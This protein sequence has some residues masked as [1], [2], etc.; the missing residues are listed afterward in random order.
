M[1][2]ASLIPLALLVAVSAAAQPSASPLA[3]TWEGSFT[4]PQ[5]KGQMELVLSRD[6]TWHGRVQVR[7]DHPVP[8]SDARE[9]VVDG[10]KVAFT[11]DLMGSACKTTAS[12][13]AGR[14][15][16]RMDCGAFALEFD[17]ARKPRD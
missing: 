10:A 3:G 5:G 7:V 6:S 16:G 11:S 15:R 17:L 1:R 8:P 4:A 13:A 2:H 14:L 9:L 12:A